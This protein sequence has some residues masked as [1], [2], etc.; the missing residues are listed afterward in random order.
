[1]SFVR[2]TQNRR[3]WPNNPSSTNFMSLFERVFDGRL[4]RRLFRVIYSFI[5][6][7]AVFPKLSNVSEVYVRQLRRFSM[8]ENQNYSKSNALPSPVK[9]EVLR[10]LINLVSFYLT[11]YV[12]L[13]IDYLLSARLSYRFSNFSLLMFISP[14]TEVVRP[15]S[16]NLNVASVVRHLLSCITH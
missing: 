1:M 13:F 7:Y 8:M 16:L 12:L 6:T 15:L 10:D 9:R 3:L 4:G 2:K 11:I 5:L 14:L